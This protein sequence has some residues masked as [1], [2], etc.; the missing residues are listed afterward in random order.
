VERPIRVKAF[1]VLLDRSR[2]RHVVWVAQDETK[3]PTTF[4]RLLGGHVEFGERSAD[5]VVRE[6][7]EELGTRL[8][9]VV[10]LGVLENVFRY[11]GEPG[12]EVVFVYGATIRDG[13]VPDGGAWFDDGGAIWVEWRPVDAR[14]EIPLY[15]D[16]T[17]ALI[18]DWVAAHH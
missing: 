7:N 9:E 16:G 5:A 13:V 6:I 2:S 3:R 12:H 14:T 10:L 1:A 4:H 15:P 8:E 17:Q 18:D 11:A